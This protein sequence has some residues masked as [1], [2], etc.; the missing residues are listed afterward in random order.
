MLL[1][2]FGGGGG[3]DHQVR[4]QFQIGEGGGLCPGLW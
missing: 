2:G 1:E 3:I 4:N